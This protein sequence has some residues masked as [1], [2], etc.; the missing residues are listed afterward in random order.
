MLECDAKAGR[1][2]NL[3][4]YPERLPHE[5]T[6][7]SL[8]TFE[9]CLEIENAIGVGAEIRVTRELASHDQI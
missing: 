9:E 4:W 2:Q 3:I 7:G 6:A 8:A 5:S 1:D